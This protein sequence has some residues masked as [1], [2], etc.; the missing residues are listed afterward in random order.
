MNF[1]SPL[2]KDGVK[3]ILNNRSDYVA[4]IETAPWHKS[5]KQGS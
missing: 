2:F 4:A 5:T 1:G 3:R